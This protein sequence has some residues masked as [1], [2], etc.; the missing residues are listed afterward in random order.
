VHDALPVCVGERRGDL[1]GD[2]DDV[3]DRQRTQLVV[4]QQL[5]EVAAL[6]QLH[7]QVQDTV[8]LAE[9]MD[10]GHPA[11][12]ERG[13]HAGLAAEPLTQ[14]PGEGLVVMRA[15]R[16]EALHGDLTAQGRV[17]RTPHLAHAAAPDQI[18]QPVPA[19]IGLV[20]PIFAIAP[21]EDSPRPPLARPV[22][23]V[24]ARLC[25]VPDASPDRGGPWP[26]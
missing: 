11:V 6:Q 24:I 21:V 3:G 13:G 5:T 8:G 17:P 25:T 4:L 16:L 12:L 2:L 15:R 20:S 9:V 10:D 1:V 14:D 23:R 18:E 22:W 19:W 26:G 7:H